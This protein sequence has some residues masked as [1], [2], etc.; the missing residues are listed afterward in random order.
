MKNTKGAALVLALVLMLVLTTLS[1]TLM[2]NTVLDN[3]IATAFAKQAQ[4]VSVSHG[5]INES[6]IEV[7]TNEYSRLIMQLKPIDVINLKQSNSQ[8]YLDPISDSPSHCPHT[9]YANDTQVA[10]AQYN[11][12]VET[13]LNNLQSQSHAQIS[14]KYLP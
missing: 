4:L 1:V 9:K 13:Q 10:C 2:Q 7:Q 8:S 5:A 11:M 6:I 3:K 12:M 14:I